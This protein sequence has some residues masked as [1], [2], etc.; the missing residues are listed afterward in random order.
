MQT[1]FNVAEFCHSITL[2]YL[3]TKVKPQTQAQL[4]QRVFEALSSIKFKT[5]LKFFRFAFQNMG[6]ALKD[7]EPFLVSKLSKNQRKELI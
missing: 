2:H 6:I 4:E 7:T 3:Q 5:I 1:S